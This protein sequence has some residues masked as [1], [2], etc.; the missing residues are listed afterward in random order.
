MKV[1][2]YLLS[3]I[4]LLGLISCSSEESNFIEAVVPTTDQLTVAFNLTNEVE[5]TKSITPSDVEKQINTCALFVC[6]SAD[7]DAEIIKK[8]FFGGNSCTFNFKPINNQTN[9]YVYAVANVDESKLSGIVEGATVSELKQVTASIPSTGGV[10]SNLPKMGGKKFKINLTN[11]SA[12]QNMG[13]IP[14]NQLVSGLQLKVLTDFGEAQDAAFVITSMQWS[15]FSTSGR[16]GGDN[17]TSTN[18]NLAFSDDFAKGSVNSPLVFQAIGYELYTF[19][20]ISANAKLHIEGYI[21]QNGK[22]VG[23]AISH[24]IAIGANQKVTLEQNTKYDIQ[25]TVVGSLSYPTNPTL[26]YKV[27][28]MNK[29]NIEVPSFD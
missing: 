18:A 17:G 1:Y 12:V 13:V 7:D 8:G 20:N 25:L 28:P 15:S 4:V 29:V 5:N 16:I 10:A 22:Q 21:S 19:P 14:V 6:T 9:Y 27:I 3:V 11:M 24:D 26:K 23:N 2:K